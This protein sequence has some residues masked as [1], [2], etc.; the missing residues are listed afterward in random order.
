MPLQRTTAKGNSKDICGILFYKLR[1]CD[2]GWQKLYPCIFY[3][4]SIDID[5]SSGYFQYFQQHTLLWH[6]TENRW[7]VIMYLLM[8]VET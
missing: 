7:K 4:L 2:K 1:G 3:H 6:N 5:F 8:L